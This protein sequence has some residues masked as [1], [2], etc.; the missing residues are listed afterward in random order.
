ME[1]EEKK[2]MARIQEK[3]TNVRNQKSSSNSFKEN[4]SPLKVVS[5]IAIIVLILAIYLYFFK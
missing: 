4:I 5:I 2:L 3:R 1:K